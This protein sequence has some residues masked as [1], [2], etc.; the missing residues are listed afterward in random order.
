M[1]VT[2]SIRVYPS[3]TIEEART[4]RPP[5]RSPSIWETVYTRSRCSRPANSRD[6]TSTPTA[7]AVTS[8]TPDSP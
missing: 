5:K 8:H 2:A 1:E 4:A 7:I 3:I 6:S